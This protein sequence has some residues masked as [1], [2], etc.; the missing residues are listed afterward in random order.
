MIT[1]HLFYRGEH[2][3]ARAFAQEMEDSGTAAAIRAS[4]SYR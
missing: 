2:G 1:V 4:E 3:A